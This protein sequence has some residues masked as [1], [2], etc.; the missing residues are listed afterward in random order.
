M[1]YQNTYFQTTLFSM[2]ALSTLGL[3]SCNSSKSS[4][5]RYEAVQPAGA[6]TPIQKQ[7]PASEFPAPGSD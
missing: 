3:M 5:N 6:Q 1:S 7:T 2:I 4:Q